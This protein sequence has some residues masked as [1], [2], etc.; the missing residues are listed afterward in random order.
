[1]T[2]EQRPYRRTNGTLGYVLPRNSF[3]WKQRHWG[4]L[5]VGTRYSYLDLDSQGIRG[6][7]MSDI[8]LGLT[9]FL[10]PHLRFMANYVHAHLNGVGNADII[11]FRF[12]LE[13]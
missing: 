4:A 7:V 5:Q 13:Y 6:G 11:E 8:T 3:S 10:R 12:G 2:G 9:W 1:V